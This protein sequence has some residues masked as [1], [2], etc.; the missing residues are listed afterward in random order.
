MEPIFI[1]LNLAA[2]I[3][4]ALAF[5]GNLAK[6]RMQTAGKA[7]DVVTIVNRKADHYDQ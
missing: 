1:L 7:S 3:I 5:K 6:K 4:V 2:I